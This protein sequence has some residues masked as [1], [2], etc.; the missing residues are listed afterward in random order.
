LIK[1]IKKRQ[2]FTAKQSHS[3]GD[4]LLTYEDPSSIVQIQEPKLSPAA[5]QIIKEN[6][7]DMGSKADQTKTFD[8]RLFVIE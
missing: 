2:S 6:I 8:E 1:E 7:A 3:D 4:D 5:I